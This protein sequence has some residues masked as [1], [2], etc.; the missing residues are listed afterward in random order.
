MPIVIL[1]AMGLGKGVI[2]TDVGGSSGVDS[3][4]K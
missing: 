3:E 2:S 4:T 1:E